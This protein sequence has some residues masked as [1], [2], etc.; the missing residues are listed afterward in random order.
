MLILVISLCVLEKI[1][2]MIFYLIGEKRQSTEKVILNF[3][4]L[5][6]VF[7]SAKFLSSIVFSKPKNLDE[8]IYTNNSNHALALF[9][10]I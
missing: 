5:L 2:I 8:K 9:I 7:F 10:C 6:P 3:T 4:L 1:L